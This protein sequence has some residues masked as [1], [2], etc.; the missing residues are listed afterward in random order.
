MNA[1][2]PWPEQLE[3]IVAAPA[4]HRIL[5]ETPALRVLE[6]V[7]EPGAREPEHV[8]RHSSV[9]IVDRP[10]RIRYYESGRLTFES[11]ETVGEPV[12]RAMWMNPEGP[13]SVE[14]IDTSRYRAFRV[15]VLGWPGVFRERGNATASTVRTVVPARLRSVT[16][17]RQIDALIV[18]KQRGTWTP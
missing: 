9:M 6:I 18:P 7:I 5:L 17:T 8:H 15:E 2:W 1:V 3:G 4:S 13:H 12:A 16:S 11:E 10:A 14:N